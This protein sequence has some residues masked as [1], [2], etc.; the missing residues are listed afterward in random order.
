MGTTE[1]ALA[2]AEKIGFNT[3]L[4]ALHPFLNKAKLPIYIAN[5]VLMDYGTGAIFGCPAHDQRDLDFA[6]KYKLKVLPV[7]RPKHVDFNKFTIT[8]DAFIEDGILFNSDFL[9]NLTVSKAIEKIIKVIVKKK[10]GKKKITYRLKD[11]GVSRQRYWG[12]PIPIVYD[13]KGKIFP[14]KKKIYLYYYRMM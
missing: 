1:E 14:V 3:G 2:N 5:F 13:N 4:F 11:W 7:V 6:N 8:N 9:N 10:L 12:C